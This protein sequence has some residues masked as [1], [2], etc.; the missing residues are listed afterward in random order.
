MSLGLTDCR[1]VMAIPREAV[2]TYHVRGIAWKAILS[3][4]V[5]TEGEALGISM[6]SSCL[7]GST[8]YQTTPIARYCLTDSSPPYAYPRDFVPGYGRFA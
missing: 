8:S 3:E 4:A 6:L 2:A 5:V 1:E 7:E